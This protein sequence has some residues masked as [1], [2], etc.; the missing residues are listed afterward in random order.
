MA[1]AATAQVRSVGLL[2]FGCAAVSVAARARRSTAS[3][4]VSE[5][6]QLQLGA[7]VRGLAA[8]LLS[9]SPSCGELDASASPTAYPNNNTALTTVWIGGRRCR[10]IK[11]P[12][13]GE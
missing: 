10:S 9:F 12:A 4:P 5:F 3:L 7:S 13:A 2:C 6:R 1:E 11:L 8:R